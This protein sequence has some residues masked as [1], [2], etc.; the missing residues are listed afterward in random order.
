M[1]AKLYA[2]GRTGSKEYVPGR[3]TARGTEYGYNIDA[4]F[5]GQQEREPALKAAP[6]PSS[7]RSSDPCWATAVPWHSSPSVVIFE[8]GGLRNFRMGRSA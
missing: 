4:K 1:A 2:N 8:K 7:S 6:V 5:E 3:N